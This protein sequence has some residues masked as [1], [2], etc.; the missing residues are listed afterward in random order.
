MTATQLR[1][2]LEP[3]LFDLFE[4]AA[5]LQADGDTPCLRAYLASVT[6][7]QLAA[8]QHQLLGMSYVGMLVESGVSRLIA[9]DRGAR[10]E[11][12]GALAAWPALV[13]AELMGPEPDGAEQ[14]WALLHGL[15]DQAWFPALS[16]ANVALIERRLAEDVVRFC[17]A[18]DLPG[19]GEAAPPDVPDDTIFDIGIDEEP[20]AAVTTAVTQEE[21]GMLS[22][23]IAA[24]RG[25]MDAFL[26]S[27]L[28]GEGADALFSAH[29]DQLHNIVN[30]ASLLGL[31]GLQQVLELVLV[32]TVALQADPGALQD[33]QRCVMLAWPRLAMD[34]LR[35][36][37]ESSGALSLAAAAA[38]PAWPY[39]AEADALS[40]WV[41]AMTAVSVVRARPSSDRAVEALPEHVDL[42]VPA[43]IDRKVL[44][45][46]LVEL[47]PHAQDFSAVVQRLSQGGSLDDL[48]QARRVAH[49]LKGAANTVGIKGVAHLTHALEDILVAFGREERL[50]TPALQ[51]VLLEA[52]DCLEA[53]GEALMGAEGAPPESLA[54]LQT[55]LDWANRIDREGLPDEAE[56]DASAGE[57]QPQ[58]LA[59]TP[60][61]VQAEAGDQVLA[62]D[63]GVQLETYLR[64]PA[65]LIDQLLK[66]A[67][68]NSIVT[69]QIQDRVSRLGENVN[70][71]RTGS[72]QFGQLSAELEQL[73][74]VR[75]LAMLGGHAGELDALEMDQ[76]NELHMLSRR[77]VESGAD[78]REFSR[79][80]DRELASLRDLMA[81]KE[82]LQL[83]LQRS[84]QRT[85]MVDVASIS[86]RLQRTVR[87]A[88][89]VLDRAVNLRIEGEHTMVDTQLLDRIIDPLMHLLRNA[90]DHG[91]EPVEMRQ[92][93]GKPVTG[94]INLSFRTEGNNVAVRC[95][96]DG[97]G[98]DLAAIHQRAI[99]RGLIDAGANL[100][101]AQVMRLILLPGFSTREQTTQLSG[102]GIGMDVVQRAVVDLRGTLDMDSR[103]GQGS[104][105]DLRFPVR[106][107]TI[108]VMLSRSEHH[109]LGVS[110]RG[111]EQ[112]LPA[113]EEIEVDGQGAQTYVLQGECLPAIRLESLMGLPTLALQQAGAMEVA[114]I[115]R[116]EFRQRLAIIV[117]ELSEART[118]VVKP[119]HPL[120]PHALG[121]DGAT[122]LGD[123]SVATVVDLPDL[124]R[125]FQ[126]GQMPGVCIA[127][128]ETA[129][130]VRLPLCLV[131]DDSVSVRRTM[132]QLMQDSGYEVV[133]ARDG[134]DALGAVQHRAPDIVLV[135]LEMPRMNGLE[136]TSALRNRS[137]TRA[138]P[139]VMITSRFTDK[140]R[141]L[142]DDAGVN[143]FLTKPYSEDL[144]LNTIDGLLRSAA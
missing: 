45:S 111:V 134:V 112:I 64:V 116:D 32:N 63:E 118:V 127:Q 143:A 96:D 65:S 113:R 136:L 100:S 27:E 59:A 95:E 97:C 124:L 9:Q 34:H 30:A 123:G 106:M 69:S 21:L 133:T 60:G 85:R 67:G 72:R 44:D 81:E 114:M 105:F 48:D 89:R 142:A 83:E 70:A 37:G 79:A 46:L 15:R 4:Q 122:V 86:P 47:P 8:K 76:Y 94:T 12:R 139:V 109:L 98:L 101:E 22:E 50:P 110:V 137:A 141:Q 26:G 23:A 90:V 31:A 53:M 56:A 115:L 84:I 6:A 16:G 25:D 19:D 103:P 73:V 68:E 135:D 52:A 140:H 91:I 78:S 71:L 92:A 13:L 10:V 49:T 58:A 138:T 3:L 33:T 88:A 120:M 77:I 87:Q 117:P 93:M 55:V 41:Q 126:A 130:R 18:D 61:A 24:L 39:P 36:P 121:I 74:D 57:A 62:A 104:G 35:S 82:R 38:D 1:D 29:I 51:S 17:Q 5:Q 128:Q 40:A 28:D 108:Q 42:S 80:F 20:P 7:L 11:E 75:G 66:L 132:E 129:A 131:V 2:T 144:L 107:S 54:V 99:A 14:P 102:R 43:D 125:D 119:F